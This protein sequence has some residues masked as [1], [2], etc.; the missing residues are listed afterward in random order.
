MDR[1]FASID[2]TARL[3]GLS[4]FY[5]RQG[6]RAGEIPHIRCGAKYMVNLA[7]FFH[8]L[9]LAWPPDIEVW[10]AKSAAKGGQRRGV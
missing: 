2:E 5:I 10:E 7:D 9:G 1:Y 6:L 8:S 3:T 4:R